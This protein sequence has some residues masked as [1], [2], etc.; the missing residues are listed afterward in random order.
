M[1]LIRNALPRD[2]DAARAQAQ[3]LT[4]WRYHMRK[5][6]WPFLAVASV[7]GYALVPAKRVRHT[8]THPNPGAVQAQPA[9]PRKSLVGGVAG[10]LFTLAL[11]SGMTL[12]TRRLSQAFM[13]PATPFQRAN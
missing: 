11:R 10:A 4:D 2:V 7:A 8:V 12:A 13:S 9:P 5:N 6:P 1:Q 3:E